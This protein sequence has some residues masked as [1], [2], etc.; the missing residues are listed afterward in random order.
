MDKKWFSKNLEDYWLNYLKRRIEI[1]RY[2]IRGSV[3]MSHFKDLYD[4]PLEKDHAEML[5]KTVFADFNWARLDSKQKI[6]SASE[7]FAE[8]IGY[9]KEELEKD[10]NLFDFISEEAKKTVVDKLKER[11]ESKTT[12]FYISKYK[13]RKTNKSFAVSVCAF[14]INDKEGKYIGSLGIITDAQKIGESLT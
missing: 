13:N 6:I 14:P 11:K 2:Y 10:V 5:T 7:G 3:K 9:T 8:L 1:Y 4:T 12:D